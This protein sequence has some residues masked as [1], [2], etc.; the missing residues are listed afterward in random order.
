MSSSWKLSEGMAPGSRRFRFISITPRTQLS[1]S[2]HTAQNKI[3]SQFCIPKT[4]NAVITTPF[5]GGSCRPL[6]R[7]AA[8][9]RSLQWMEDN[10][11]NGNNPK[12]FFTIATRQNPIC[13]RSITSVLRG[14]SNTE[15]A[16]IFPLFLSVPPSVARGPDGI[17]VPP[18]PP[19]RRTPARFKN[20]TAAESTELREMKTEL[21]RLHVSSPMP[22]REHNNSETKPDA[23]GPKPRGRDLAARENCRRVNV[24]RKTCDDVPIQKNEYNSCASH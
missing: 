4:L 20:T 3:R 22:N 11:Q 21:S 17:A 18:A 19:P 10:N 13:R 24:P 23:T 2:Q 6:L 1:L 16:P 5:V 15:I 8:R 12:P 9:D 7:I 14:S